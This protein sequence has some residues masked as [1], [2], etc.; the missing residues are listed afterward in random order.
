MA[1]YGHHFIFKATKKVTKMGD[2]KEHSIMLLINKTFKTYHAG[3]IL[4]GI[5]LFVLE[6]GYLL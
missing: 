1:N 5:D 2:F 4:R 6:P 3:K